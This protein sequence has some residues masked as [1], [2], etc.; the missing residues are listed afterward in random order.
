MNKLKYS[1][2][3]YPFLVAAFPVL[4]LYADNITRVTLHQIWQ[5]LGI[6]FLLTA[7]I[8]ALSLLI[9]RNARKAGLFTAAAVAFF[10]LYRPSFVTLQEM[11]ALV[12]LSL[13]R[14][15]QLAAIF[16][17]V[18]GMIAFLLLRNKKPFLKLTYV[19]NVTAL[20][21]ILPSVFT[22]SWQAIKKISGESKLQKQVLKTKPLPANAPDIFYIVPDGYARQD[23]LQTVF[24]YNNQPFLNALKAR[25]FYIASQSTS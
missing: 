1:P 2:W 10:F 4:F 5:P 21:L 18:L 13:N 7:F 24:N 8:F 22:I 15:R 25:G 19:L 3:L 6:A 12:K 14:H 23:V 11:P 9:F 20:F 17:L 16:L